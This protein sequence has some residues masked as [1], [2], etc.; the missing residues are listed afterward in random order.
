MADPAFICSITFTISNYVLII[1]ILF[2]ISS[3]NPQPS[4]TLQQFGWCY[5]IISKEVWV[6]VYSIADLV[7]ICI[8]ITFTMLLT[9]IACSIPMSLEAVLFM[10]RIGESRASIQQHYGHE[11]HYDLDMKAFNSTGLQRTT[12]IRECTTLKSHGKRQN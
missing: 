7:F 11:V 6:E 2:S 8:I 12:K 3:G 9:G 10:Q 4:L 5:S 1:R